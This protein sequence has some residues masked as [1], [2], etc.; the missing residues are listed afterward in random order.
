MNKTFSIFTILICGLLWGT[1]QGNPVD[2]TIACQVAGNFFAAIKGGSAPVWEDITPQT[3]FQEFYVFAN[4]D[5]EGFVIVSA[6]D[7]VQPILGYSTTSRVPEIIPAHTR[8]FLQGYEEEILHYKNNNVRATEEIERQ[9]E[10]L[11]QGTFT[12]QNTT[13]V[14]PLLTSTWDQYPLYNNLCPD[15]AGVHA[16]AGCVAVATA[17][18]MR[19]WQ[20]PIMGT[21]SYSYTDANFGYQYA[22]FGT[23]TYQWS[24]MPNALDYSSSS[25]QINAVATLLYHVGVAVKMNYGTNIST[26]YMHST[27]Q[28]SSLNALRNYFGYKNTLHSVVKN[29]TSDAV[30]VSTLKNELNAGRPVL[31]SGNDGEIGHAFVCDGYDNNNLFHINWGWGSYLDGYFAHNA[32][33][34][35]GGGSGGNQNGTYNN[36]VAI[37]V[38]IEP[39]GAPNP[40]Q[41]Y[42]ITAT[43]SNSTMGSVTGGGVYAGSNTVELRAT[44]NPG[45]RFTGWNDGVT[46]NPRTIVVTGNTTYVANFD[47]LGGNV[48]HYDN[49]T[50]SGAY[51]AADVTYWG[52]RFPIGTLSPYTTLS[53]IR[54]WDVV[55]GNYEVRI[56]QGNFPT[57]G[58][59]V[60]SQNFQMSG[61][62]NWHETNLN[63]P[64]TI[65]HS[66]P[67]WIV[68]YY[69]GTDFPAAASDYAGTDEASWLSYDGAMWYKLSDFSDTY[70]T[71]MVRAVLTGGND[72]VSEYQP[73][74]ENIYSVGNTIVTDGVD[75]TWVEI[76][77]MTGRLVIRD[78]STELSHRV[79][80]IAHSGVYMVRT[81]NGN[82]KKVVVMR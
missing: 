38:G 58:N 50:F 76:Y 13:S 68:I 6:D 41:Q 19:F 27:T 55:A 31:E 37:L 60:H 2:Q 16:L 36:G 80:P 23:T 66:K 70:V 81:G 10:S 4:K 67:L 61:S 8:F 44:A 71:W 72:P 73:A 20:W 53:A 82:T 43:S 30:W 57:S 56:H 69:V 32:L 65:N 9:W 78:E 24:L 22:N 47:N 51:S 74:T 52:I 28:P 40:N 35:N 14:A 34:P 46:T 49:G 7:C 77:D 21:G 48:R 79:F 1:V 62:N 29:G 11:I 75:N 63:T 26:A 45:Y 12:P 54:L 42:T 64:V 39:E 59:K 17:Q 5:G 25:A 33:N 3:G 18:V 15:S